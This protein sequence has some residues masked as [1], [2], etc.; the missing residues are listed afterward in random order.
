[1]VVGGGVFKSTSAGATWAPTGLTNQSVNALAIN[2]ATPATPA[3]LYAGT[4]SGVFRSTDAGVTWTAV[5]SGLT[6]LVVYAAAIDPLT[7]ATLYAG[8]N[9][10]GVFKSLNRGGTWFAANTLLSDGLVYTLAITDD[11]N[12]ADGVGSRFFNV[13][14]GV[15]ALT[16]EPDEFR[17][18]AET[19]ELGS[20]ASAFRWNSAADE[21][22]AV[23]RLLQGSPAAQVC[24]IALSFGHEPHRVMP[25]SYCSHA[26]RQR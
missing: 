18:K 9:G 8:T 14:A 23:R 25:W 4:D 17:L 16:A 1:M 11:C 26:V 5:I 12:R 20:V 13:P 7:P 2:P 15:S 6:N 19:T 21:A 24:V 10:G 3:T 22:S